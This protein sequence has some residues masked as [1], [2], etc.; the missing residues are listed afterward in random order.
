MVRHAPTIKYTY[1]DYRTTPEDQRHE[2]L[3]GALA[4]AA[5]PRIDHQRVQFE[6][7]LRL[8]QFVKQNDLGEVFFSPTDVMLSNTD[9]VQ[10]DLLF[11]SHQRRELVGQDNIQGA[12]DLVVEILSPAS[13]A[14]DRGDKRLLYERH[15]VRE[16]WLV[17]PCT[18]TV[19]VLLLGEHGFEVATTY[20]ERDTLTSVVLPGFTLNV[21]EIFAG[22][23]AC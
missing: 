23:P 17:E 14:R 2:L 5:A 3:D 19:T 4:M 6:L 13:A 20:R 18:E 9:V 12:P 1:E 11:I 15:G 7:G 21:D 22:Y 10:P 16:Y 8:G